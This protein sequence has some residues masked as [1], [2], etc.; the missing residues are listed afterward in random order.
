M[1]VPLNQS[2]FN[3]LLEVLNQSNS[4]TLG[5]LLALT[6]T[7]IS[8]T[9]VT[10]LTVGSIANTSA[11]VTT[12][13][14]GRLTPGIS[15]TVYYDRLDLSTLFSVTPPSV[16]MVPESSLDLLIPLNAQ[17]GLALDATDILYELIPVPSTSYTMKALPSSYAYIGQVLVN[18]IEPGI[19]LNLD[20]TNQFLQGFVTQ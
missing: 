3:I 7:D 11:L 8:I 15:L 19:D 4:S 13:P 16:V 10:A 9:N 12:L 20:I 5:T 6:A 2:S 1:T 18:L 14:G 17:F